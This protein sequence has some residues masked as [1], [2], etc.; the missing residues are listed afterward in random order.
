MLTF[1]CNLDCSKK[2]P[3]VTM[4]M[5]LGSLT[6]HRLL[7]KSGGSLCWDGPVL[8][9]CVKSPERKL[10]LSSGLLSTLLLQQS[11]R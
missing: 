7:V 1:E 9:S 11:S 10:L 4:K 5:Q 3:E 8:L 6:R 2:P